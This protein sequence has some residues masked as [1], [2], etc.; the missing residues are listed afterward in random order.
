M[1]VDLEDYCKSQQLQNNSH[2]EEQ[3]IFESYR[4]DIVDGTCSI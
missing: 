2:W 4:G 1:I 3:Q